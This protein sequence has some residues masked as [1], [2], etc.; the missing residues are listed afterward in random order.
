LIEE[1]L[2]NLY[3]IEI[4]IPNNPLKSLNSYL[5]KSQD[6]FL[7]ID[8]G[9]NREECRQKMFSSLHKLNVDLNRTDFFI[10]H[11]HVDH[12]GLLE[13]LVTSSSKIYFNYKEASMF[14]IF[15]FG[16]ARWEELHTSYYLNGFPKDLL[17]NSISASGIQ[18]YGPK[19]QLEFHA[20][21][22]DY[23]IEIGDY[24]FRCIETPGHSPGHT[25]LYEAE[26][27]ILLSGDHI[28]MNITPNIGFWFEMPNSLKEYLT[29]L[30]RV[31]KLDVNLIL[32]G[33]RD[34]GND[35]RKRIKEL[36]EHHQI[37]LNEILSALQKTEMNAF[38][39]SSHITWDIDAPTWD[40]FPA[41]QKFF[42]FGETLAHLHYLE[43]GNLIQQ[44]SKNGI[45]MF[46]LV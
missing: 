18:R 2:P 19:K 22:D 5:I 30:E 41:A 13:N 16:D 42:A 44:K 20:I 45:Q 31:Y 32:P 17:T 27:K 38:E 11:I 21:G 10:T 46:S 43:Q 7:I 8:T 40:K 29:S 15:Y 37:R 6:R 26:K 3:K 14:N 25:C 34:H 9:M 33:H 35:H 1:I 24:S 23:S 4:P 12:L 39:V 36:Q 28:L